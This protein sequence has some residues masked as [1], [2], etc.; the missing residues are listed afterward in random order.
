[1]IDSDLFGGSLLAVEFDFSPTSVGEMSDILSQNS[2]EEDD[3]DL[4]LGL[5]DDQEVEL[6]RLNGVY[7]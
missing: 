4:N 7:F 1:M 3:F 6:N 5:L 2:S